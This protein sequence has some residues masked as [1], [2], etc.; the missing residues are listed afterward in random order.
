MIASIYH[1]R[2]CCLTAL[3]EVAMGVWRGGILGVG[4]ALAGLMCIGDASGVHQL[5]RSS[6]S[7]IAAVGALVLLLALRATLLLCR[8]GNSPASGERSRG[9]LVALAAFIVVGAVYSLNLAFSLSA[10]G[11]YPY[12][13]V[14]SVFLDVCQWLAVAAAAA[15]L[16][17]LS[18]NEYLPV[19]RSDGD[20]S[21]GL[22]RSTLVGWR[23]WLTVPLG[24]RPDR[25]VGDSEDPR[26]VD[27]GEQDDNVDCS[28]RSLHSSRSDDIEE[29]VRF[30]VSADVDGQGVFP[31][32]Q[33]LEPHGPVE[34][35]SQPGADTPSALSS[36]EFGWDI[37]MDASCS[38]AS[39]S[40]L[41][42]VAVR[43]DSSSPSVAI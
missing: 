32:E 43:Y 23:G 11:A 24:A 4:G 35:T 6:R 38:S 40:L 13:V 16:L 33:L 20:G 41:V 37:D 17:P 7:L 21:H 28:Q 3:P 15:V 42:P 2:T 12:I 39:S 14:R 26:T 10:G 36:S 19:N 5:Q 1:N 34:P 25:H 31:T 18:R 29:L 30:D 9:I 27:Q 22:W 8:V